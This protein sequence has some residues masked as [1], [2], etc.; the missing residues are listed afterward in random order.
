VSVT[1]EVGIV[2][3]DLGDG[4]CKDWCGGSEASCGTAPT[5]CRVDCV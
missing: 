1:I 3:G 2:V 5:G 4:V